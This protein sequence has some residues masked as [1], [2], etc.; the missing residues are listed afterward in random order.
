VNI[1]T[2]ILL[3]SKR[4]ILILQTDFVVARSLSQRGSMFWRGVEFLLPETALGLRLK[5]IST[6]GRHRGNDRIDYS[7]TKC[8]S[9]GHSLQRIVENQTRTALE[10]KSVA[11]EGGDFYEKD[12]AVFF[13]SCVLFLT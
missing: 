11:H 13:I 1:V 3:I 4:S 8:F 5:K 12:A 6:Q 10:R 2:A 9:L 7:A